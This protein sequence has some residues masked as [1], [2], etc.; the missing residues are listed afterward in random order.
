MPGARLKSLKLMPE[1][2]L[3]VSTPVRAELEFSVDGM[4]A[5][6]SGKSMVSV[7]WIGKNLGMVNFILGGAGLDK[8]KYP[9]RTEVACGLKED[10]SHQ[11]GRRFCGRGLHALL[12]AGGRRL[13]QLRGKLLRIKDGTLDCSRELK[14]KV[15]EFSPNQY[16]TLK[17]TLK[18][19][20]YD[21]R[22]VPVLA[23]SEGAATEPEAKADSAPTPPVESDAKILESHKELD[24]DRRAQRRLSGELLQA[25][26]ELRRQNQGGRG[27]D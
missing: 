22:K 4:T 3:D 12:P 17:Q 18:S 15:V 20:E 8:R 21:E 19:M 9:M 7:P 24:A 25:H 5:T 13:R 16:L 14:L 2:M 1:D 23:V 27:E 10:I 26:S 6:G 11:N